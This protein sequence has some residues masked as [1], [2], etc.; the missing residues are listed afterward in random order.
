MLH[1]F[2]ARSVQLATAFRY[3]NRGEI[4]ELKQVKPKK[5]RS[6]KDTNGRVDERS[7]FVWNEESAVRRKGRGAWI[8][9]QI[10]A[11]NTVMLTSTV[12]SHSLFAFLADRGEGG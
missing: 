3:F 8:R 1:F 11:C 7:V 12:L 10:T 9:V 2:A 4:S 5:S 6:R